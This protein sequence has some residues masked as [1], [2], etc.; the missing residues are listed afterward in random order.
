[1]V[2]KGEPTSNIA[3]KIKLNPDKVQ[4]AFMFKN[5]N[6]SK[7]T[8]NW[9]RKYNLNEFDLIE[10]DKVKVRED[11]YALPEEDFNKK[12]LAWAHKETTDKKTKKKEKKNL[13]KYNKL[14]EDHKDDPDRLKKILVNILADLWGYDQEKERITSAY[15]LSKIATT[16]KNDKNSFL[17]WTSEGDSYAFFYTIGSDYMQ[18]LKKFFNGKKEA[19]K[20]VADR[21]KEEAENPKLKKHV[22]KYPRDFGFPRYRETADSYPTVIS[23]ANLDREH[24]R[25]KLPKMPR[26]HEWVKIWPNQDIPNF[27]FPSKNLGNPRIIT[28]GVDFYLAFAYYA[29]ISPI[30]KEKGEVLGIDLGMKNSM[31]CSNGEVFRNIADDKTVRR[32][33]EKIK[34]YARKICALREGKSSNCKMKPKK[35]VVNRTGKVV[36]VYSKEQLKER[37]KRTSRQIRRLELRQKKAQIKLNN[38]KANERNLIAYQIV[39]TNPA[40]IVFENLNVKGMQ[41]N[42]KNSPRLQKTGMY[43]MKMAVVNQASKHGIVCKHVDTFFPSSQICSVCGY[44]NKEMKDVGKRTYVCPSCGAVI[45]RDLNASYNLKKKW[46]DAKQINL[47][48]VDENLA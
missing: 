3:C 21:K 34:E 29:P 40:G 11:L 24:K 14:K 13:N 4:R 28:D 33:E 22:Y 26:G 27:E 6:I 44:Q 39:Q 20:R 19:F 38:Y 9:A 18:A 2:L 45:D 46:G 17:H 16:I 35:K 48:N 47:L 23:V 42:K 1:M 15:G 32:L 37:W 5:C 25:V 31:I 43:S 8:F 41:K 10:E 36:S 12:V 7:V 30:N